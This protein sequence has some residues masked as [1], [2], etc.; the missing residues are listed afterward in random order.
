ML[1]VVVVVT[2]EHELADQLLEEC[3][4]TNSEIQRRPGRN[5][6]VSITHLLSHS[7]QKWERTPH[8]RIGEG[9][10]GSVYLECLQG[11]NGTAVRAVKEIK[12]MCYNR[13]DP[14]NQ[15]NRLSVRCRDE[16]RNMILLS[17]VL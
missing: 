2:M 16:L 12:N 1:V 11:S 17:K 6:V 15:N 4:L 7:T 5:H 8:S 13:K 3:K 9:S 14:D 10:S